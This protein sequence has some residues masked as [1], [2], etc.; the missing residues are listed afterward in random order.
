MYAGQNRTVR[1]QNENLA[2]LPRYPT[3]HTGRMLICKPHRVDDKTAA[4][5]NLEGGATLHL[6]LALRGGLQLSR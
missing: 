1:E 6:V 3:I 2:E 4:E 5:Y